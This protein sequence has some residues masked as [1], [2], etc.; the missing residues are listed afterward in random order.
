[1][2]VRILV[3]MLCLGTWASILRTRPA[4][5]SQHV[6][7]RHVEAL[8]SQLKNASD[9]GPGYGTEFPY[10][11]DG[12]QFLPTSSNPVPMRARKPIAVPTLLGLIKIGRPGLPI[13]LEHLSD[14]TPTKVFVRLK[15]P[16]WI[17]S[18][19]DQRARSPIAQRASCAMS[20][21]LEIFDNFGDTEFLGRTYNLRAGD[22]CYV[23][24]GQMIGRDIGAV[25][26]YPWEVALTS[27]IL[28]PGLATE[29]TSTWTGLTE[30]EHIQSLEFD[31]FKR[32]FPVYRCNPSNGF[33]SSTRMRLSD[34]RLSWPHDRLRG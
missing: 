5:N 24:I 4:S 26:V 1:M 19:R 33:A 11:F 7:S 21:D 14:S 31:A 32:R 15:R 22:I 27:P 25:S 29:V 2:D 6:T 3:A 18:E 17:G 34:L 8:V 28:N 13:L 16:T 30:A 12:M 20:N 10:G 9:P 23:V